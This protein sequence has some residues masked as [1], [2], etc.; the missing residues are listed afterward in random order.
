MNYSDSILL[1]NEKKSYN[2]IYSCENKNKNFLNIIELYI[3]VLFI[4]LLTIQL[5]KYLTF[6]F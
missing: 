6:I 2:Q 4:F 3:V 5:N 1:Q